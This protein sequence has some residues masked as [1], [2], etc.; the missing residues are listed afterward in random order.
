MG[1]AASCQARRSFRK[2][3]VCNTR[4]HHKTRGTPHSRTHRY[5][6]SDSVFYASLF[7]F[8]ASPAL[9]ESSCHQGKKKKKNRF[10]KQAVFKRIFTADIMHACSKQC[11]DRLQE[12]GFLN[13]LKGFFLMYYTEENDVT[14]ISIS[15]A[16][17]ELL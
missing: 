8:S 13:D 7:I 9:L 1:S 5:W 14:Y 10:P 17:V 16:L 12:L 4:Q 11:H 2:S 6:F 3:T 15:L